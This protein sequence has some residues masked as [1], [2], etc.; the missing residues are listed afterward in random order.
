MTLSLNDKNRTVFPFSAYTSF[1][2]SRKELLC[3]LVPA[4]GTNSVSSR[5]LLPST[6]QLAIMVS[7]MKL[8]LALTSIIALST[9]RGPLV[10][11][12]EAGVDVGVTF[13]RGSF[14]LSTSSP[15]ESGLT[16][17]TAHAQSRDVAAHEFVGREIN[18]GVSTA[19]A[20]SDVPGGEVVEVESKSASS[21][22]IKAPY[23]T[24]LPVYNDTAAV[25]EKK[26]VSEL[27]NATPSV[28]SSASVVLFPSN[29][30]A[31]AILSG[32]VV[33]ISATPEVTETNPITTPSDVLKIIEESSTTTILTTLTLVPIP[34]KPSTGT[35]TQ[36]H[37]LAA[38][39]ASTSMVSVSI[40]ISSSLVSTTQPLTSS[41][42]PTTA[43]LLPATGTEPTATTSTTRTSLNTVTTQTTLTEYI[44][45]AKST[46]SSSSSSS[47]LVA[48]AGIAPSSSTD[49][50]GTAGQG[51]ANVTSVMF[52]LFTSPPV[53]II[54]HSTHTSQNT[55]TI[56]LSQ[57]HPQSIHPPTTKLNHTTAPPIETSTSTVTVVV[58]RPP[59]GTGSLKSPSPT[60]GNKVYKGASGD[61]GN[62]RRGEKASVFAGIGMGLVM[63]FKMCFR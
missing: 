2:S 14:C 12:G 30:S 46:A 25:A 15:Y 24:H 11:V 19:V 59:T 9:A 62:A 23:P 20:F 32:P 55:T 54:P 63:V 6:S 33:S 47:I 43:M 60:P 21:A 10:H 49:S 29:G 56:T 4:R 48:A 13:S 16:H 18:S 40:S 26:L 22:I 53:I 17:F 41:Q 3:L 1:F 27:S 44:T 61:E 35:G 50:S 7:T 5:R 57:I 28:T 38:S 58:T 34:V 37:H 39:V 51:Q 8:V 36:S 42:G 45:I 31:L 52:P